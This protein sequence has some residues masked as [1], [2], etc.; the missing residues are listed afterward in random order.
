DLPLPGGTE[1]YSVDAA[2]AV[3]PAGPGVGRTLYGVS[4]GRLVSG[5]PGELEAVSGIF[6]AEGAGIDAVAVSPDDQTAAATD[7][8]GSRVLLAPVRASA[9]QT[10]PQTVLSGGRYA[11]PTWDSAGRLWVLER[12]PGG[13]VVW[14]SQDGRLRQIR[15]PGVTG[16]QGRELIVSRDGTR[17]IGVVRTAGGDRVVGARVFIGGR[18]RVSR[19]G[20]PFL[21]RPAEGGTITDLCWTGPIRVG[22]LTTAAP[23]SLYEIDVQAA[24]GATVG[25]DV[26]AS[27]VSGKV[28][29][30]AG[31][32]VADSPL[33]S[34]QEDQYVDMVGQR[35]YDATP[36]GLSA[37]DYAG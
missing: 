29:G 18:G 8:G 26:L 32:P 23:D 37:L 7:L 1:Q 3:G 6:G 19:T 27:I 12:R 5:R 13:S 16:E 25:G 9:T 24:D 2:A 22:I 15:V 10:T 17:L 35:A 11:R 33:F 30:I 28:L 4:Q 14:L 31:S 21:V 20:R 34:L 36:E